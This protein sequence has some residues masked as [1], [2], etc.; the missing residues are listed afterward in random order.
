MKKL[1]TI[2]EKDFKALKPVLSKQQ[3]DSGPFIVLRFDKVD[4]KVSD[5]LSELNGDKVNLKN[6]FIVPI[7]NSDIFSHFN[8]YL[9]CLATVISTLELVGIV[10]NLRVVELGM[11]GEAIKI[12]K[13]TEE[14]EGRATLFLLKG[15]DEFT[16]VHTLTKEVMVRLCID[17]LVADFVDTEFITSRQVSIELSHVFN[18]YREEN[19]QIDKESENYEF[20]ISEHSRMKDKPVTFTLELLEAAVHASKLIQ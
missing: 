9:S 10:S 11:S 8:A 2:I 5:V 7:N 20:I 13:E 18:T 19:R 17:N 14:E 4:K 3:G 1:S 16:N 6:A 12:N 15:E